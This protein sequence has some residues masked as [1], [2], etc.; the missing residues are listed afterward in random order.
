MNQEK[1]DELMVQA[2]QARYRHQLETVR[3]CNMESRSP[4]GRRLSALGLEPILEEVKRTREYYNEFIYHTP[5]WLPLLHR[6]SDE[7]LAFIGIQV[8]MDI[9]SVQTKRTKAINMIGEALQDEDRC[10]WLENQHPDVW[11]EARKWVAKSRRQGFREIARKIYKQHA[12]TKD[13]PY[14]DWRIED[15]ARIG[16]WL[17]DVVRRS[18]HFIQEHA[19]RE[20]KKSYDIVYIVATPKCLEWIREFNSQFELLRPVLMP[21]VEQPIPWTHHDEGGYKH[22]LAKITFVKNMRLHGREYDFADMGEAV[23]AVNRLQRVPWQV[24]K[25]VLE[26]AQWAAET[27]QQIGCLGR[28]KPYDLPEVEDFGQLSTAA[29]KQIIDNRAIIHRLNAEIRHKMVA[30]LRTISHAKLLKDQTF[31]YPHNC[32]FRGRVYMIPQ[33][34]NYQGNDLQRGLLHFATGKK[35]GHGWKWL[36]VHGANVYGIKGTHEERIQ[37]VQDHDQDIVSAAM[38]PKDSTFWRDA[39]DPWQFL[40]FCFEYDKVEDNHSYRSTLPVSMDGSCNGYQ[41]LAMA[42]KDEDVGRFVNIHRKDEPTD[43]YQYILER[44]ENAVNGSRNYLIMPWKKIG[45]TRDMIKPLVM[46]RPF[47]SRAYSAVRHLANY[48]YERTGDGMPPY[49]GDLAFKSCV[50]MAR[51][52]MSEVIRITEKP[53]KLMKFIRHIGIMNAKAQ[54]GF[55]WKSPSGFPVTTQKFKKT[56]RRIEC[57]YNNN[58][59]GL[60]IHEDTGDYDIMKQG[61]SSPANFVHSLDAGVLHKVVNELPKGVR[62]IA[63]VHDC[64]ATLA[65]DYLR[66]NKTIRRVCHSVFTETDWVEEMKQYACDMLEGLEPE[67]GEMA[68][69]NILTAKYMF[70]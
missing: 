21:M 34:L 19:Q 2:G 56:S 32:D 30:N 9:I 47:G 59:I 4:Y 14:K 1:L 24:N 50:L 44:V 40:A 3:K 62:A 11:K 5:K 35:V 48:Y 13:K 7:K 60:T 53:E 26:V 10:L 41:M 64:Y 68:M 20:S 16:A 28:M 65:A 15:R 8:V 6:I 57:L 69:K 17:L 39:K 27:G 12:R 38:N 61:A 52:V 66:V 46:T 33:A 29:R 18:T 25:E 58:K 36:Y 70:S 37:W 43:L 23:S 67:R 51:I 31:Y 42:C 55:A 22:G 54:R 49:L 45:M 63:T